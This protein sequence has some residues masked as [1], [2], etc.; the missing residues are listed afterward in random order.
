MS[1]DLRPPAPPPTSDPP[2]PTGDPP[3]T[4]RRHLAL[5]AARHALRVPPVP[6]HFLSLI[7]I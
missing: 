2:T 4:R 6:R 1:G 3:L 7:H 5:Q